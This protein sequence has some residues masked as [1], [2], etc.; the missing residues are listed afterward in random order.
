[1]HFYGHGKDFDKVLKIQPESKK[2]EYLI[3][4]PF[5]NNSGEIPKK[6]RD[7]LPLNSF[8]NVKYYAGRIT[9]V[10]WQS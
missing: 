2:Q 6:L 9:F 10:V 3:Y 8:L 1:M 4:K 5:V 7:N